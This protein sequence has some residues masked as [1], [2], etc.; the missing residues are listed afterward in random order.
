M[1][2]SLVGRLLLRCFAVQALGLQ[3][4]EI[5]FV[6]T[7]RGKPVLEQDNHGWDYNVSHAGK[8]E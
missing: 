5:K 7:D 4:N 6:R 8:D 3:N 2:A 1:V